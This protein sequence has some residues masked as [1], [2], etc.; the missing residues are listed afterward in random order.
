[1]DNSA[2]TA[3]SGSRPGD[4]QDLVLVGGGL[5][6]GL[7]AMAVLDRHPDA[8]LTLV[9]RGATLGGNHTWSLHS[10]YLPEGADRWV[11]PLIAHEWPRYQVMF[12]GLSRTLDHPYA[13]IPSDHF[14]AVLSDRLAAAPNATLHLETEATAVHAESVTVRSAGGDLRAIDT[15]LVVDARG[16]AHGEHVQ[17]AGYQ[18][19][20]GLEVELEKPLDA[21]AATT[22]DLI[23]ATVSQEFGY[24]FVYTLPL[25]P[26]R[27]LVED[28][29]FDDE[30]TL[31]IAPVR[32]RVL[33]Y[34]KRRGLTV[35]KVVREE[36]GVLPMPW[37]SNLTYSTRSPLIAGFAGGWFHPAT[38]YSVPVAARLADHLAT[39]LKSS[40]GVFGPAYRALVADQERQVHF[41]HLL[42]ELLFTASKPKERWRIFAH[43]Y[44][45]PD[46]LI[47]RFYGLAMTRAD[48]LRFFMRRPPPGVKYRKAMTILPAW[49]AR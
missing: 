3:L 31:D 36:H 28:T 34:A 27:V 39:H 44:G 8:R 15:Q 2:D 5:Q 30:P 11:R 32:E 46:P 22:A 48:R 47:L 21:R 18:K 29:Y 20:V 6:N 17:Q 25:T 35:A 24:R 42:N 1:M 43:F 12:P 41:G 40:E 7:I 23:D 10:G 14:H 38:G 45:L 19:F 33:A 13:T 49:L 9:E 37:R 4:T 26:T 16:P